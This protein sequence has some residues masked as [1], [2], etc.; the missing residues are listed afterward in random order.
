[1]RTIKS[2]IEYHSTLCNLYR[3]LKLLKEKSENNTLKELIL[4]SGIKEVGEQLDF[5]I[6]DNDENNTHFSTFVDE[7]IKAFKAC[8]KKIEE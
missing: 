5:A 2:K 7:L 6:F 3:A 1:M 4:V 8:I